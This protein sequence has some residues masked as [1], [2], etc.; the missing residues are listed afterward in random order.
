MYRFLGGNIENAWRSL[1][2]GCLWLLSGFF[3]IF[4]YGLL[5]A[6]AFNLAAA[7]GILVFVFLIGRRLVN[8]KA[9]ILAVILLVSDPTFLERSRMVRTDFAPAMFGL[10]AFYLFEVGEERK[11]WGWYAASGLGA[12]A[13][14]LCHPNLLY[15]TGAI[16]LIILLK[17]G[18]RGLISKNCFQFAGAMVA[19]LAYPVV[20]AVLDYQN[21]KLQYR[22]DPVHFGMAEGWT[23]WSNIAAEPD[24]YMAWWSGV[25]LTFSNLPLTLLHV[26]QL[27]AAA[28]F[29]Y[30]I[31][32]ALTRR[33]PSRRIDDPRFRILLVTVVA[34]V[35]FAIISRKTTYY[36]VHIESWLALCAGVM[37]ADAID[38]VRGLEARASRHRRAIHAAVT[39]VAAVGILV[40]GFYFLRQNRRYLNAVRNPELASFEEFKEV[41]RSIVPPGVCP[42]AVKA[43]V[44][45]MAF[46]ES[47]RCFATI[48]KRMLGSVDLA[49][50]EYAL[51]TQNKGPENWSRALIGDYHLLGQLSGT[52]YGDLSIYYTGTNPEYLRLPAVH[53]RFFER[54]RGHIRLQ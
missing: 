5:Q 18:A 26:F 52:P 15:L 21:L 22:D 20:T 46:P 36:V 6:R 54:L 48:E 35:F 4:G 24:R 19:V 9:G 33:R 16:L 30:L 49:G 23:W 32:R 38:A 17:R 2:P 11:S 51:V 41:I 47:D 1:E 37:L 42:V 3:K 43:P 8:A 39:A 10:F 40:Y 50:K 7:A 25:G 34:I 44:I 29:L 53:Y 45:W 14:V 27:L 13:A 28:G 31:G 12:G